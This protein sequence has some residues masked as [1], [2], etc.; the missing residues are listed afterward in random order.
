M[1]VVVLSLFC[2]MFA[3]I[4]LH[5]FLY[6]CNLFMWKNT[7]INQNFIFDF[8]PNT[9]L[10]HRD[11]FLMSASIMCTVVATLVIN[12]FLRNVGAS[13]AKVVP[14]TL[15]VVSNTQ[16]YMGR[17]YIRQVMLQYIS[18][19]KYHFRCQWEF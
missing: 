11:A 17:Q 5:C 3:L 10:T 8:A 19:L 2:S 14:G 1:T 6:G 18:V 16:P 13:Y 7:R 9:T 4:S 15:I 12:L